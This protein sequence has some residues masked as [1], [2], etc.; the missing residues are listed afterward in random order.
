[1]NEFITFGKKK[2]ILVVIIIPLPPFNFS[3][4][5]I[6]D[7]NLPFTSTFIKENCFLYV[8]LRHFAGIRL[9]DLLRLSSAA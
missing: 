2:S 1:M 4:E 7:A 6:I 8:F 9:P 3:N 5:L